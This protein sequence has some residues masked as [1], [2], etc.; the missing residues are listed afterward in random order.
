LV[1]FAVCCL[2]QHIA[3]PD[4]GNPDRPQAEGR[5]HT[6]HCAGASLHPTCVLN[7]EDTTPAPNEALAYMELLNTSK[8]FLCNLVRNEVC[9][10]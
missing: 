2:L 3:I 9:R 5:Y 7:A 1:L 10:V 4:E 6:R 8:L